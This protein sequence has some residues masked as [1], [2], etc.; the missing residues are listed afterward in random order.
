MQAVITLAPLFFWIAIVVLIIVIIR[1]RNKIARQKI[2]NEMA[3]LRQE[4]ETLKQD[5]DKSDL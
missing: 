4:V 3:E 2:E 5:N 1:H